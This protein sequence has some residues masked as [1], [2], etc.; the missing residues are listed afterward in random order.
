MN[1]SK[2]KVEARLKAAEK[3]NLQREHFACPVCGNEGNYRNVG[4]EH[5]FFCE[6]CKVT[7]REGINLFSSW[8]KET[9]ADWER[10]RHFLSRFRIIVW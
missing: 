5:W 3:W 2:P 7:W 10:N 9:P 8:R 1:G 4:R 6:R